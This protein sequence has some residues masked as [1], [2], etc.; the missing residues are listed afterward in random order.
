MSIMTRVLIPALAVVGVIVCQ[1]PAQAGPPP[2]AVAYGEDDQGRS[3]R[4]D[5]DRGDEHDRRDGYD[6]RDERR[7]ERNQ[8]EDHDRRDER[9][10]YN[11]RREDR[12]RDRDDA[13][14]HEYR[15]YR[16]Y[17]GDEWPDDYGVVRGGRCNT[18]AALGV[19][20]AVTGGV[21]GNRTASPENRG[22][23]TVFG[24]IAGGIL[25]SAI[26]SSI[27]DGDRACIGHSLELAPIGRP[28]EWSNPRSHV[29]WRM[30]PVRDV[31][32]SCREFDLQRQDGRRGSQRMVA[33]RRDRGAWQFQRQ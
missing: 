3:D 23:A 1:T 4:D 26:G 28:V 8:H 7:G 18:D 21:I 13:R 31:S 27:D 6:H 33:C 29:A 25:G 9:E 10:Y 5:R 14:G 15:S 22:I 24:A 32:T 17:G 19:L 30:V 16:G 11:E 12:W 20:G 2:W